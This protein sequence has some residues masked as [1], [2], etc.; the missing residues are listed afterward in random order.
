MD[1]RPRTAAGSWLSRAQ[2]LASLLLR[3]MNPGSGQRCSTRAKLKPGSESP[4]GRRVLINRG[5]RYACSNR[6]G[7]HELALDLIEEIG[8]S[9]D[10]DR[11]V[12]NDLIE[13][14]TV[15]LVLGELGHQRFGHSDERLRRLWRKPQHY[16]C[17]R[18][19]ASGFGQYEVKGE[20]RSRTRGVQK[21][22]S[23]SE[24]G[25]GTDIDSFGVP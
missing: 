14:P 24:S 4:S 19:E 17:F 2:E 9:A 8:I 15:T 25:V 22:G 7:A 21:P 1:E 23:R 12:R 13:L 11:Q 20:K 16:F 6:K 5:L 10:R 3:M 18:L